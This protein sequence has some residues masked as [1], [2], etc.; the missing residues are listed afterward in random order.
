MLAAFRGELFKVVRRPGVWVLVIVLLVLAILIG[1]AITWLIYTFPPKGAP[2]KAWRQGPRCPTSV[3]LYPAN[4]VRETLDSGG[5]LGACPG[6]HRRRCCCRAASTDG[7]PSR[8]RTR[9]A[10]VA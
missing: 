3:T 7:E 6:P 5:V 10:R 8:P 9:S 4:F 2:R 1:Y